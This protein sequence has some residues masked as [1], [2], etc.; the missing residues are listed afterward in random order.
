M[1]AKQGTAIRR[2]SLDRDSAEYIDGKVGP[3]QIVILTKYVKKL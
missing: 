1:V 3:T 2:I